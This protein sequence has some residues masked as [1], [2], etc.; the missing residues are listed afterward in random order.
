MRS[1]IWLLITNRIPSTTEAAQSCFSSSHRQGLTFPRMKHK[2]LHS[3]LSWC[4]RLVWLAGEI[5]IH[6]AIFIVVLLP[7]GQPSHGAWSLRQ[8]RSVKWELMA[9]NT[10]SSPYRAEQVKSGSMS[11]SS[12][13]TMLSYVDIRCSVD[14]ILSS[15]VGEKNKL[16]ANSEWQLAAAA[17]A[18]GTMTGDIYCCGRIRFGTNFVGIY[19]QCKETP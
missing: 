11:S 7:S 5:K 17:S 12:W 10:G 1:R 18:A 6:Y 3:L 2:A 8:E 14:G 4:L 13:W 9:L 15:V 16:T 19:W